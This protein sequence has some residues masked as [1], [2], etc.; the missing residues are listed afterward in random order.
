MPYKTDKER[1]AAV[2][3]S[4]K[5]WLARNTHVSVP[6][7]LTER[8]DAAMAEYN[9]SLPFKLKRPQFLAAIITHWERRKD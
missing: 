3:K 7:E 5:Q 8:L 9:K 4:Q 2:R 6:N 1:K